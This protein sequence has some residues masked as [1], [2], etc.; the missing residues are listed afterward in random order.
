LGDCLFTL[1]ASTAAAEAEGRF[2]MEGALRRAHE[3]M[4]RRHEH[5]F[6]ENK[7]ATPQE[8]IDSWNRIKAEEKARKAARG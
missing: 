5:V 8:A 2:T 1:L 3:K 4:I 7:A 6:G